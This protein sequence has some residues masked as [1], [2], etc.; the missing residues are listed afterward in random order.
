MSQYLKVL[1]QSWIW[2]ADC[3]LAVLEEAALVR[4]QSPHGRQIR[5][6]AHEVHAT[7]ITLSYQGAAD[8]FAGGER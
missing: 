3:V 8:V 2:P 5:C 6:D 7:G 1:I 4:D